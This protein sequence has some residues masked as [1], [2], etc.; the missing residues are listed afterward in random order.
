[1]TKS[2]DDVRGARSEKNPFSLTKLGL[3]AL[4]ISA[5]VAFMLG[6]GWF[7]LV[8]K[9]QLRRAAEDDLRAVASLKADQ[10][11]KWRAERL[12]DAAVIMETPFLSETAGVWLREPTEDLKRRILDWFRALRT[13]YRYADV[14]LV[15]IDGRV[16]LSLY[17]PGTA[18]HPEAAE[19]LAR[20]LRERRPV[21]T[22]LHE[23]DGQS[24]HVGVIAPVFAQWGREGPPEAAVVLQSDAGQ[25]LYPLIQSWPTS[26]PSAETLLVRREGNFVL[27][28]NELRHRRD[29]ALRL[30]IPLTETD[31]PAVMA[32]RGKRG[33]VEGRDYRG[34]EVLADVRHIPNTPWFMIAK[35]DKVDALAVWRSRSF[36]I[37]ALLGAVMIAFVAV[38]GMLRQRSEKAGYRRLYEAET[39]RRKTEQRHKV[40]LMSVGDGVITTDTRGRVELM[41]PVAEKLTGWKLDDA[42]GRPLENVFHIVEETSRERVENPVRKV[43]R[44]GTIV[45]LAN[46]SILIARDGAEHPIADSGAPIP[47]DDGAVSGVVLVFRDQTEQR[48]AEGRLLREKQRAQQYLDTAN[49]ILI[50]LDTHANVTLVNR[51]GCE[52]LGYE[53]GEI[54]GKNWF[55]HFVPEDS[56]E[57]VRDVFSKAASGEW[58]GVEYVENP[59]LTGHG[60][61]RLIAWRNSVVRDG[62]GAIVGALSSGEDITDRRAAEEALRE[63]EQRYRATFNDASVGIDLVDR[64]GA[65]LELNRTLADFLGYTTN[66]L[67]DLTVFDVTHP[68]DVEKSAEMFK[69]L[70]EDNLRVYRLEKRYVRKDGEVVWADTSVSTIRGPEGELRATV[71]V[72]VDI[73]RRK[74][75]EA[76]SVLLA[77]AVEHAAE[78]IEV[79]DATGRIVYVNPAFEQT[80]GYSREEVIGRNPSILKSGKHDERF[81]REMWRTLLDGEV[82]TGR[83]I[84]K[85]KDGS[86]FEEDVSI[87]PVKDDSGTIVN[88]VAVKRD[89]TQEILLERQ[90]QQA[91]KLESIAA[92]AGGIAHDF[93]N[94][95][96]IASGYTEILLMEK[97]EGDP[98]HE[99]LEA[100]RHA[101]SRGADLVRSILTFSRQIETFPRVVDINDEIRHAE[102]LMMR[103][104]PK[105]IEIRLDLAE[106][107]DPVKVDAGQFEQILLNLAVNARD[108]MPGGG[109]L[110]L[111]TRNVRLD[112][113]YCRTHL[114]TTPG[115]YVMAEVSD[116]GHGMGPDEIER[117][118]E[119]F[120]ST[121]RPGEGTGL[122]LAMVFGIVKGHGGHIACYSE[123]GAGTVFKIYFPVVREEQ[124]DEDPAVSREMTAFGTETILLVDDEESIRSLGESILRRA[125]YTTLTASNGVEGLEIYRKRG[126]DIDL[127]VLDMIMP[128]MGGEQCLEE[129]TQIDPEV[130]VLIASGFS[131]QGMTKVSDRPGVRGF[132][133]K[134]FKMS[135]LLK[136]VRKA[137]DGD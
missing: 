50:A 19:A 107:V 16:R 95:L 22:S 70:L 69:A 67:L 53:E 57:R 83:F 47:G 102:K 104:I 106:D 87:T 61:T 117:I 46:H 26:N 91:Q 137:L 112:E 43:M 110:T 66:E 74:E 55:E 77:T 128:E 10:I 78:S 41:N 121:K 64:K 111:R 58:S 126:E 76:V 88:Y 23:T 114:G 34:V 62:N 25:F 1:M 101:A 109:E 92:L 11:K 82:W 131:A 79:T 48:A 44:K 108:A 40:T 31:V 125:G 51:K 14:M 15:D 129:L 30:R 18:L 72:I 118:F 100:I 63:S 28:L 36:L 122:G 49:T 96:T 39:A 94:L 32:I 56:V 65:F 73:T 29:S 5:V 2:T 71:G 119:P 134:P 75:S 115:D 85:K 59:I 90:L 98:G 60:D 37:V 97:K 116:T 127:V 120:Y 103:T 20:A 136:T 105:M 123:P 80:T 8:E 24:S 89:V 130:K 33:I 6:G 99:E 45:G 52:I 13:H 54:L 124:R 21:M 113:E 42:Q 133:G 12:G 81:Y 3:S 17:N 86:L 132:V 7:Y 84:N 135:S 38:A 93:N 9:K 4:L 35:V 68:D 27:F